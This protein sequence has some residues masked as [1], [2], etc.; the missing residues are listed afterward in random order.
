M[1]QETKLTLLCMHEDVIDRHFARDPNTGERIA[2]HALDALKAAATYGRVTGA[3][4]LTAH[5]AITSD[6]MSMPMARAKRARDMGFSRLRAINQRIDSAVTLAKAERDAILEK[7]AAPPEPKTFSK[8]TVA[9]GTRDGLLRLSPKARAKA[10]SEA[11]EAGDDVTVG[12]VLN[13][14]NVAS[15]ISRSEHDMLRATWQRRR[16]PFE[17]DRAARLD[18]AMDDLTNAGSAMINFVSS[19]TNSERIAAAEESERKAREAAK[20]HPDFR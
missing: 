2:D 19:L 8:D 3:E 12:A 9:Q 13:A 10:L 16:F 11:V 15:G 1:S 7:I 20:P 17:V 6:E 14:P 5:K 4:I 18:R